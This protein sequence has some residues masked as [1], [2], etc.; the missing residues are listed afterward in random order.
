M[1][2]R[3]SIRGKVL[4]ALIVPLLVLAA[5]VG[6]ISYQSMQDANDARDV[7]D[8][9]RLVD[10]HA[11]VVHTM[12][13][14][15]DV[16][17]EAVSGLRT[18]GEV[19]A[20]QSN[21]DIALSKLEVQLA[22]TPADLL[23]G[24]IAFLRDAV[25]SIHDELEGLRSIR[26]VGSEST[27]NQAYTS[28][29]LNVIAMPTTV[30]DQL[31]DPV[32]GPKLRAYGALLVADEW[33]VHEEALAPRVLADPEGAGEM[34]GQ[35]AGLVSTTNV[36]L[37]SAEATLATVTDE[38]LLSPQS[39]QESSYRLA[40]ASGS[41]TAVSQIDPEAYLQYT[42][43][44]IA[45]LRSVQGLIIDDIVATADVAAS[46]AER[47]AY[48]TMGIGILAVVLTLIFGI[49]LARQ[50]VRPMRR[51]I[52]AAGHVRDEL[53]RLVEQVAVPGQGPDMAIANIP[54]TS[55]DE[56]G[57]LA[58]AFNE[59]NATTLR[60]AQEQAALRG[61]IAEMFVNVA[62]RDQVLLNRQ[63]TFID[64]LERSEEDPKVLADLFRL[65]HL[66]TRMRRNAESLLVLAG[67][68][69]GRRLRD[70]LPLSDMVRTASS[71][72]EH[73]ERV[74]L[75]LPIDPLMLGHTA[76]PAAHLL[77]ELLENA[78][79][80]SEPGS[81]V[82]V[83]TGRDKEHVLVSIV[84][85]GLGMS[86]EEIAS[87]HAKIRSSSPSEVLGAQRLGFFVVGRIAARLGAQ[88]ELSQGANGVGTM[89][90]VRLP[91][92][93]FADM[94]DVP[95]EAPARPL[96]VPQ[97]SQ[98]PV[99]P[100]PEVV[101]PVD[102]AALTDG[103]TERG[104]P[105]RRTL[106]ADTDGPA[107]SEPTPDQPLP[108]QTIPVAPA[109]EA[110]AGAA[111][112]V[113]DDWAPT[114]RESTP[115]T[116]RR[117]TGGDAADAPAAPAPSGFSPDVEPAGAAPGGL[118]QR[119]PALPARGAAPVP[120]PP[121]APG[122]E[123]RTSM[124]TGFRSRRA[125]YVA[126]SLKPIEE[127]PAH[128][129]APTP[130]EAETPGAP[131]AEAP[132]HGGYALESQ[133]APLDA[134]LDAPLHAP[135]DAPL[136]A[137]LDAPLVVPQLEVD[138]PEPFVVPMLEDD[139]DEELP[140]A[141]MPSTDAPSWASAEVD[142]DPD[143]A[144]AAPAADAGYDL[145][146]APAQA[147][148]PAPAPVA[149]PV[150]EQP[151]VPTPAPVAPPAAPAPEPVPAE[152][153]PGMSGWASPGPVQDFASLVQG[154]EDEVFEE[155][156]APKKQRR[157]LFGRRKPK[158]EPPAPLVTRTPSAQSAPPAAPYAP[159]AP[160]PV[161]SQAPAAPVP[162]R[163]PAPQPPAPPAPQPAAPVASGWSPAVGWA[164]AESESAATQ[165]FTDLA[166]SAP[167]R[168]EPV[169]EPDL[170]AAPAAP[171]APAMTSWNP[172]AEETASPS[173]RLPL[174]GEP[175]WPGARSRT[176]SPAAPAAPAASASAPAADP[177]DAAR[178]AKPVVPSQHSATFVP[179]DGADSHATYL[180][181]RAGIAQQA[182]AE[183]SQLSTYRPQTVGSSAAPL[184]RR[185]PTAIPS[186]P[187]ATPARKGA[188]RD[189]NQ[190]RSLLASFQSGTSRGRQE[191]AP[192]ESHRSS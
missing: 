167:A 101:R 93:L 115:L 118:P 175:D 122:A 137:P 111:G 87:A 147:P 140:V 129:V 38:Q 57:R 125:E 155:P 180:A 97:Q 64:A 134:P 58:T 159:A 2:R 60:V 160:V 31:S 72:I 27:I 21:T 187:A 183:L 165:A 82:Y 76:L 74:V 184:T 136:H 166:R 73:Y 52:R 16:A 91:L 186:T 12:Q 178:H 105:R 28:L 131:V 151:Y 70:T 185:T 18:P 104:L 172:D 99:A 143:W 90:T 33:L 173:W 42:D 109:A 127:T 130:A 17:T 135:L 14:E 103:A 47:E 171:A 89:A 120:E 75:D 153:V 133:R 100:E 56:V 48:I 67:I 66:A 157:G 13:H 34:V 41:L 62:R 61:S 92:V 121:V 191:T 78:T 88:V 141:V 8:V 139:V 29:I 163:E 189:A 132:I 190:V 182:L 77:A 81:P 177:A 68:D 150:A 20:A 79:M 107:P 54:V 32:L 80:F 162:V 117:R 51:L 98:G 44:R 154:A 7:A 5:A 30:A 19:T 106:R 83:S 146:W 55:S 63:L 148:A 25:N 124:F 164:P 71:E 102:L 85:E 95:M 112:V 145:T 4:V 126:A 158:A 181:Q 39:D 96:G 94:A 86:P 170:P 10:P 138:E 176:E 169:A 110:L 116:G 142:D 156:P 174:P 50:I 24:R 69:T 3:L 161:A 6:L 113:S 53:P 49:A 59:V 1:L 179:N 37:A 46:E 40:L 114:I 128:E 152:L 144:T 15:R 123:S 168:P 119:A 23:E 35:L 9:A 84:D 22:T 43:A 65:D 26:G 11:A 45:E 188:P 36:E 108:N 149:R 192:S